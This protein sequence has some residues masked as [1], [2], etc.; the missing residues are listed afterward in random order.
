MVLSIRFTLY[1]VHTYNLPLFYF[2][3]VHLIRA[4]TLGTLISCYN[5]PE[6]Y[7]ERRSLDNVHIHINQYL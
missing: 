5:V 6:I 2:I 1:G 4:A 7:V 3:F